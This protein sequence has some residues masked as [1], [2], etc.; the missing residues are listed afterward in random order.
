MIRNYLKVAFRT[1]AR[2]KMFTVINIFGLALSMAVCMLV[3]IRI[4]DQVSFDHFHPQEKQT[5]RIISQLTNKEGTDYRFATTPLPFLE[6][7]SRNYAVVDKSTRVFLPPSQRVIVPGRKQLQVDA[8]FVDAPFFEIFGFPFKDGNRKLALQSPNSVVLTRDM[9]ERLFGKGAT[10]IGQSIEIPAWGSF[11]VTAVLDKAPGKSHLAHDA[12][13]SMSSL[14]ALEKSG[15]L[16]PVL[17]TWDNFYNSYTYITL[18]RQSTKKQLDASLAAI[19]KRLMDSQKKEGTASIH[20]ESQRLDKI[21]LGEELLA[22]TRGSGSRSKVLAEAA[23]AIIILI[24]ASFNYTNL[25]IAR[26]LNR[27]KEVGI[28][29]VSGALRINV[30]FQFILESLIISLLAFG[31]AFLLLQLMID[32]VPFISEMLPD[33]FRFDVTVLLWFFIF[34]LCTGVLAGMLPAWALSS[35]K[36]VQVLKNLSTVKLFGSHSLRKGLIVFQFTLSLVIVIFTMVF[37]KQF[38]FMANADPLFNR[39]NIM[40]VPL[41]GADPALLG[42]ELRKLSG[43]EMVTAV[44][45]KPGKDVSGSVSVKR[46]APDQAIGMDY[47]DMASDYPAAIGL[48]FLAGTSFPAGATISHERYTIIN[49]T[50]L[51]LLKFNNP[52][53]AIGQQ[54]LFSDSV[55]VQIV[56]VVK[57]FYARGMEFAPGPLL[58]RNRADQFNYLVVRTNATNKEVEASV[59]AAIRKVYPLHDAQPQ[60]LRAGMESRY[61]PV[62]VISMLGFLGFITITIACLG[63]LGMVTYITQTRYKEIGIRKV[64]GAGLPTIMMILSKGFLKLVLVAGAVGLPLGWIC[65]FVFLNIFTNRVSIGIDILLITLAGMLLLVLLTISSQIYRVAVANPVNALRN[66]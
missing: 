25:S 15:K 27:G 4:R 54:V 52:A 18:R 20:F 8:V 3:L 62:G 43:V 26:S 57:N 9:A 12:Y 30:F 64:L 28:R 23:I 39:D 40:M 11:V 46:E 60:W 29:K 21:V 1:L 32:Y 50:A 58:F 7:L 45:E 38:D 41:Q 16:T 44:S 55:P 34:T 2:N 66:E 10:V 61:S 5:Y 53:E 13:I 42:A 47:Y 14:P 36:P 56:G 22:S 35:F 17:Q 31:V 65:S 63:L 24:S 19:A 6:R 37:S 33:G 59:H 51:R 48:H 49:E